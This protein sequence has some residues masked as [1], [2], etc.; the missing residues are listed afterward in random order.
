MYSSFG[1][2]VPLYLGRKYSHIKW[3]QYVSAVSF[4]LN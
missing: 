3:L 4:S 2:P 1:Y